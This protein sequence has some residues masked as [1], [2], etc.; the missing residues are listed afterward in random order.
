MYPN[1]TCVLKM[2]C[3]MSLNTPFNDYHVQYI[4][5]NI[6]KYKEII[7]RS[8]MSLL[9]VDQTKDITFITF[10]VKWLG[11]HMKFCKKIFS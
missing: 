2:F 9:D 3:N 5:R 4:R 8:G 1:E 6:E 10:I 11:Y 7:V